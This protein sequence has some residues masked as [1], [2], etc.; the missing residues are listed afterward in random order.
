[1]ALETD[2][3]S[4][5]DERAL[6]L[7]HAFGDFETGDVRVVFQKRDRTSL[8]FAPGQS[9]TEAVDPRAR[10]RQVLTKDFAR[11]AVTFLAI[12]RFH[13]R[14]G[15]AIGQLVRSDGEVIVL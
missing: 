10:D 14:S 11:A 13:R 4:G 1:M 2:V 12:L 9:S 7:A 5:D 6:F 15:D 8:R 3:G